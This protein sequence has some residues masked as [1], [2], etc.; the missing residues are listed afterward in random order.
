MAN[1]SGMPIT[2]HPR[3]R[4][5]GATAFR[6]A[7]GDG[8][9]SIVNR[10]GQALMLALSVATGVALALAIIAASNGV[11]RKVAQLLDIKPQPPQINFGEV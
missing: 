8:L 10:P 11:E 6:M 7:I 2:R 3:R 4:V 9:R 5:A 1:L